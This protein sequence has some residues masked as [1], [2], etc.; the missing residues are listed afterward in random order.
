LP[1]FIPSDRFDGS[2]DRTKLLTTKAANPNLKLV[3][4]V[5]NPSLTLS[6]KSRTTYPAWAEK[7]GTEWRSSDP[8]PAV[9]FTRKLVNLFEMQDED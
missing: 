4:Y 7:H 6:N 5:Q 3:I 1:S 8:R 2:K 9:D